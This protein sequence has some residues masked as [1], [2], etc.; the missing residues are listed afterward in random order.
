MKSLKIV[1]ILLVV[2]FLSTFMFISFAPVFGGKQ[3]KESIEKIEMSENY[4]NGQ[5]LNITPTDIK[6]SSSG[7][8]VSIKEWIFPQKDKNPNLPLPSAEFSLNEL[9]DNGFSWLGHSTVIMKIGDITIITDPVFHNASPIPGTINPFPMMNKI[10]IESIYD[11]DIVVISHDHYDHLDYK[12]FKK[13]SEKVEKI[14][15]PL[16]VKAHLEKWGIASE[17]VSE[18]DWYESDMYQEIRLTLTPA[19]HFSGR[20]LWNR[21]S[22]LW[23]GWIIQ[24]KNNNIFFSGDSGYSE[25]FRNIG[26]KYGPFDIAFI[27]SGAYNSNWSQI[28][29]VPEET[30]QASIDLRAKILLPIGWAKFDL[31]THSWND[32]AFRI[33]KSASKMGVVVATPLIGE[34]FYLDAIPDK[35]WWN[36]N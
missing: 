31:S 24:S 10:L 14:F 6:T 8:K 7:E 21:N 34:V 20:S 29:M 22:T 28:H 33:K 11:I 18:L 23:G 13:I 16:G 19:R 17:K 15:V 3:S 36:I 5:F 32:P 26:E 4:S 27:D 25:I 35:E 2:F 12:F 1:F 30:V 9:G